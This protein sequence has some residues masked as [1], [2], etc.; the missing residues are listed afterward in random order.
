MKKLFV[1][2][3]VICLLATN[4]VAGL[5][6][7]DTDKTERITI[8]KS[9]AVLEKEVKFYRAW[10]AT[11]GVLKKMGE[12]KYKNKNAG[13]IDAKINGISVKA[14]IE[15]STEKVITVKIEVQDESSDGNALAREIINKINEKM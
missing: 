14:I 13:R 10:S 9:A 12:I 7:K 5:F 1:M 2:F 6:S 8:D 3:I 11:Y 4:S 15:E